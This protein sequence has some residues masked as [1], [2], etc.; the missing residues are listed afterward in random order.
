MIATPSPIPPFCVR[1]VR[2]QREVVVAPVGELD[3]ASVE[4]LEDEIRGLGAERV[5]RVILDLRG[6]EFIDSTGLRLLLSTR[7]TALREGYALTVVPGPP[8]VQ[9]VFDLTGTRGLFAWRD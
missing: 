2:N 4:V 6:V 1:V 8:R 9:R 3:V 7:N 5:D